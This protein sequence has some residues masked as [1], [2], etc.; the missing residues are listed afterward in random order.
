MRLSHLTAEYPT[1]V[2]WVDPGDLVG[3]VLI[4]A[5]GA[6]IGDTQGGMNIAA[7]LLAGHALANWL[8]H[9]ATRRGRRG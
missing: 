5:M 6:I 3:A 7:V 8:Y 1:G 4:L 2:P 9:R